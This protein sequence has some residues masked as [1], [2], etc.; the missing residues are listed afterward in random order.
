[1]EMLKYACN[2]F[3]ALKATFANEMGRISQ[4][5][6]VDPHEVMQL[7]C[8][9]RQLNISSAYL[10]PGFAFGGSCLPKDLKALLYL[11]KT[12][13]VDLPMMA[14]IMSSN[15]AHIEHAVNQ[16]LASGRRSVG[17]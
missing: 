10:R 16:V 5:A 12:Q 2:A 9:D 3:H 14:N 6:G 1:A 8:M 11:A 7:L 17:M 13:D 4:A 15:A